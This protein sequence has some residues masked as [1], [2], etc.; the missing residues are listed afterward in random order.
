MIRSND[1]DLRLWFR[2]WLA[3][4]AGAMDRKM[5]KVSYG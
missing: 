2:L 5:E 4:M 1:Y 3:T